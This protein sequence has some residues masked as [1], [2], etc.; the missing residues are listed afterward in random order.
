M[1]DPNTIY[2][3]NQ[4]SPILHLRYEEEKPNGDLQVWNESELIKQIK[5]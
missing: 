3:G 5:N 2:D 1:S 4:I